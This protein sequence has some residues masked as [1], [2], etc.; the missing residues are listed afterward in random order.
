[1]DSPFKKIGSDK[2]LSG[3]IEES[4]ELAIRK[5]QYKA[6]EK[7]PTEGELCKSFGVSRTVVREAL[8]KLSA[9]GLVVIKQG[10]RHARASRTAML[11]PSLKLGS[12]NASAAPQTCRARSPDTCPR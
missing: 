12:T 11:N 10:R 1:M 4:I 2:L 9:R 8:R 6:G 5:K 7:L 3:K